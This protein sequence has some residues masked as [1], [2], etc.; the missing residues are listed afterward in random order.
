MKRQR[1]VG[2]ER[3]AITIHVAIA[4]IALLS[5]TTIVI[6]YGIMWVARR[7][8]QNAADAAALAGAG[9]LSLDPTGYD[10]ARAT[11]EVFASKNV[12]W[13]Q[14][15]ATTNILVSPLPFNC[16]DG[17]PACIRVD[18]MRGQPD[19]NG[20]A[21]ANT[22]PTFMGKMIGVNSQGIR[23]TATAQV[24]NGNAVECIKPW[25]VSDKWTDN[26]TG[27]AGGLTPSVWDQMDSFDPGDTYTRGVSGFAASGTTNEYGYQLV[28][29]QGQ[30]GTW[31]SGWTMEIDLGGSGSSD[32]QDE[33]EG[34]P[35][36]V[37]TVGLYPPS[38]IDPCLTRTDEDPVAGCIGVKTGMSQG[39]T[40]HGVHTLT[41]LDS[42]AT[43]DSVN[44]R[45]QGGCMANGTCVNPQGVHVS[46]SPRIVPLALFD[47]AS[48]IAGGYSGTN[49]VAKV[50][51]L[52]GFFIEGMCDEVWPDQA[53][54]P[55][56]CG[57]NAE[58][59]KSVVG[60][61]MAYPGQARAASGSAGPQTF[62]KVLRLIR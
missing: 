56:Y 25:V 28:L 22:L 6:D 46:I 21:H 38:G 53:T 26:S 13:G 39:P 45:V 29:K 37:P 41:G 9:T 1:S 52:L 42:S 4:L 62:L 58:A 33:I 48:Y 43:W 47:P 55:P 5:F 57:T 15:T 3:G 2:D 19:R 51:N 17:V 14:E 24:A 50:T 11:A 18:V 60:R 8:G 23:A 61:L 36:W 40:Q 30:N 59:Q 49:G 20:G 32:Y 35:A 27:A 10:E 7:Q 12:I 31:S 44:A 34:C 16:P 54:R